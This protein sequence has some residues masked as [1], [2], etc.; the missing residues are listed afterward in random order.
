MLLG[1]YRHPDSGRA[2]QTLTPETSGNIQRMTS[3]ADA[4]ALDSP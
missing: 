3:R 1:E 2:D 4:I